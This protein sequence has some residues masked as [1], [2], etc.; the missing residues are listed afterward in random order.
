[1]RT[2]V[3]T[4][5]YCDSR[6]LRSVM[7]QYL[8]A[9]GREGGVRVGDGSAAAVLLRLH[10]RLEGRIRRDA[11]RDRSEKPASQLGDRIGAAYERLLEAAEAARRV[12]RRVGREAVT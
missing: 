5:E 1:M 4:I 12:V 11:P 8:C 2:S 9:G 3:I 6:F 10:V 7:S